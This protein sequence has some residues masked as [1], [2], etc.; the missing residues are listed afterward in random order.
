M[1]KNKLDDRLKGSLWG[2][3][4]GDALGAPYEFIDRGTYTAS[5]TYLAGGTHGLDEGQWT[6]D[7]S[8]ALC[9][10]ESI[11]EKG[12]VD[13]QDIMSKWA[14]W[15]YDGY[16][17]STGVCFD[18]GFTTRYAIKTWKNSQELFQGLN[19]NK[20]SGNGGIMRFSPIP[21]WNHKKSLVEAV[22]AG[23][24]VSNLTHP[25][26]YCQSG[27]TLMATLLHAF[28]HRDSKV[29]KQQ[30]LK[31][32]SQSSDD[33]MIK[34]MIDHVFQNGYDKIY[35]SGFVIQSL[36]AALWALVNSDNFKSGLMIVM[37]M[38]GDVD[39]VGAIYGQLA[40][41]YYGMSGIDSYYLA[42]LF[43]REKLEK[44]VNTLV[45]KSYQ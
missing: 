4:V 18:I 21:V 29:D 40:G 23:V 16:L 13:L 5:E 27:A 11:N 14:D 45:D 9:I 15:Y 3:F 20:Y 33:K 34:T 22:K 41:A 1:N 31:N 19:D 35:S 6:D 30:I 17:S 32:I 7:S 38:G 26:Q 44:M 28:Y 37:N 42:N 10:T 36:E 24:E 2:L 12:Q 39:T 25:S 43:D 8:M